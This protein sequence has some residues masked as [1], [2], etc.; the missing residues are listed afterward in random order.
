MRELSPSLF[1]GSLALGLAASRLPAVVIS[2]IHYHPPAGEENLEFIEVSNDTTTPDDISG[3]R[4][5]EGIE[6]EFPPGTILPASG[7]LVVCADVEAVKARYGIQNALGNFIGKLD[8]SGEKI[9]LA[10]HCG[11]VLQSLHYR[12][13]GKWPVAPDGTGHTLALKNA[14]L[15]PKEP[16]S[17]AQSREL[18]GS[19]GLPNFPAGEELHDDVI[20]DR[21]ET[22]RYAKGLGPFS[23]PEAAW[24]EPLFD[25]SAWL[26]G[27]S[28]FGFADND[29]N[30]VLDDMLG[31]YTSVACRK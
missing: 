30:T 23:E 1:L 21:G 13:D 8:N 31:A 9:T 15:D 7:I 18:G 29:D 27:P 4:F 28:G 19:P 5:L 20:I 2:E 22:W 16:E 3:Y 11:I 26:E 17:W 10:N 24:R 12:D 6:F 25:D 14:H